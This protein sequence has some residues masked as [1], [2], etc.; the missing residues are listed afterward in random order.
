MQQGLGSTCWARREKASPRAALLLSWCAVW[1]CDFLSE[2]LDFHHWT[3]E[4]AQ[5]PAWL[6]QCS[7]RAVRELW[8]HRTRCQQAR[9]VQVQLYSANSQL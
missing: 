2:A 1:G 5:P 9:E 7:G 3:G 6:T 4:S 8:G